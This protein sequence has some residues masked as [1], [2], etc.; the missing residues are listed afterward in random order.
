MRSVG[1]SLLSLFLLVIKSETG[2]P[3]EQSPQIHQFLI[4]STPEVPSSPPPTPT[5][6]EKK[7]D[8]YLGSPECLIKKLTRA[9][10][11]LVFC[12]PWERCVEGQCSCKPPYLCPTDDVT[13]VCGRDHRTYRSYCQV[14]AVSCRTKKPVMSY[15]GD[16]CGENNL[17]IRTLIDSETG[18]VSVSLPDKS[19][20]GVE[21]HLICRKLWDMATANVACKEHGN[22]LGAAAADTVSYPSL[23]TD[24]PGK[25][26]PS[27]C[28][29]IRCQGYENSLAECV[30]YAEMQIH[31]NRRVATATCYNALQALTDCGFPCANRK[32]V[33]LNQTCDGIDDC[34][35]R[36]DEM[37]CKGC[38]RDGL[39]CK[40]G[41]CL[42]K[43]SVHDGHVDCLDGEDESPKTQQVRHSGTVRT[44]GNSGTVR[45]NG[46]SGTVR[47]NGNSGTVRTNGNSGTVRTNGNSDF[48]SPQDEIKLSRLHLES[49][50]KCGIPN[51]TTVDD[52]EV[53]ERGR[54]PR[55]KRVVGG[56]PARPTQIQW[57]V[58]LEEH[59]KI[60]CGGAYI[61]DCWVITAAHCV[62]PNPRAFN[63]KFSL[64]RKSRAQD[65]TDVVPVEDIHI[66][67]RYNARTYENDI[68]LVKLKKL[69]YED[70]C[71][72][73]NPAISAVCV[74]WSTQL[75]QSNHTCSISG[76]G[77]TQ[78]GRSAQVLL[79]ANVSLI[80]DC[81]RFYKDRFKPG[82]MC[83][84]DLDGSVDSCQGDGGVDSCQGDGGVD[85][86]Q[87]DG[88]GPLVCEDELGVSY[89][90]G[91]SSWGERCGQPGFPGVYTQVA[92][93]FEWIRS[94]TGWPT[95]TRFNS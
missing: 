54:G 83:A 43:D 79:W 33:L 2:R 6:A 80:D 38:R 50:L 90:W 1:V 66:H 87:G 19:K 29:S 84:G 93:Y 23:R 32:C 37:C 25:E 44:N 72:M 92:H 59:K 42:H 88:G 73:D 49:K 21:K 58:A 81:Q 40:T 7:E 9:S 77:R 64:W 30:I 78:D 14:M 5:A 24:H 46:N 41:V 61:G 36:S 67:P 10:C 56:V 11:D 62:R 89:L 27:S 13:A 63:V 48:I 12:P 85:S 76:W 75:F 31:G 94:N 15:F 22:P 55:V 45:T 86:C 70:K 8:K 57:Q 35:D 68:A 26:F 34:G 74:P 17:E 47:T 18:V 51:A 71:F 39:L 69:P 3:I 65:T 91:I 95:V 16:K 20:T 53:S 82:M 52:E 60:D 28:V 4:P